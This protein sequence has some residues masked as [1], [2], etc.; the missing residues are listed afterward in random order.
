LKGTLCALLAGTAFCGLA[1]APAAA[2]VTPPAY[3]NFDSNGV[4]LVRGDFLLSFVEGSIGSGEAELALVRTAGS[5]AGGPS[6][7]DGID[8]RLTRSH[9]GGAATVTVTMA[10]KS[11]RFTESGGAFSSSLA[12]GATLAGGGGGFTYTRRDGTRI[13]F[14]D[15]SGNPGSGTTNFCK[16]NLQTSC[17]LAPTD[18]STPDGRT[19]TLDWNLNPRCASDYNPDGSLDC[20]YDRRLGA[21][22]ND[23]G[24]SIAFTYAVADASGAQPP[25]GWYQR[26]GA[27][28]DGGAALVGYAYPPSGETEV[29]DTGG[30]KWL[31]A[32]GR[33]RRPGANVD[34][35]TVT[36]NGL[37]N[38]TVA[39][40]GTTTLYSRSADLVTKVATMTVTQVDPDNPDPDPVTTIVS[41]L[42]IDRP[43]L[44]TD[45]LGHSTAFQYDGAGRLTR[46]TAHEGNYVHYDHD[47]RG[48]VTTTTRVP[49]SG[50]GPTIVSSAEFPSDCSS[51]VAC[52][53]PVTTTDERGQ[54]TRYDWDPVY[55]VLDKVTLPAPTPGAAPPQ[56]RFG[57]TLDQASGRYQLTGTSQCQTGEAPACLGTPDEVKSSIVYN[58]DGTIQST[59]TGD[60]TGAPTKTATTKLYYDAIAN[61]VRVDGPLDTDVDT[62][63]FLYN[64]ARELIRTVSPDPDGTNG[65]LRRRAVRNHYVNGRL[66]KV[67]QGNVESPSDPWTQ[68]GTGPGTVPAPAIEMSY[69][70]FARPVQSRLVSGSTV[71]SLTQTSYDALGRVDCM[72]QRMD[73]NDFG[74]SLPGACTLTTPNGAEGPDR[75]V[76]TLYDKAGR[77]AQVRTALGVTGVEA[78]E[79]VGYRPNGQVEFLVDGRGNRT[80]F[81]YDG[82][83]R[84]ERTLYPSTTLAQNFNDSTPADA[85]NTAGAAN[86]GDD[87]LIGYESV[88]GGRTSELAASF[89]NR[90]DETILFGYDLLGRMISKN[91]PGTEPD[92]GYGYDLLGRMTSASRAGDSLT[93]GWDAFGR[94]VKQS[95][96][97]GHYE[98]EYDLAGRRIRLDHPDTFFVIQEYNVTG[99][100]IAIRESGTTLLATYEYD[101]LGRRDRLVLGNGAVTDYEYDAASRLWKLTHDPAGAAYDNTIE[102]TY[103]PAG[104]IAVRTATNNAYA[105]T[106][107][108]N[109][110]TSSSFDGL[111][112]P[113]GVSHDARSNRQTDGSRTYVY[114]S[115]NKS[116]GTSTAPWH[117]DPLDRLSGVSTSPGT[118]PAIAYES[119]VDNLTAERTPG[120]SNVGRRHVFGPGVNEPLVWLEGPAGTTD[121]RF[122][123]ADERGSIVAV[124]D[125]SGAVQNVNRYDEYGRTQNSNP[126][127]QSRFAYTGQRYFGGFGLYHYKNRMYDPKAGRFMQPDPI[128]YD[129]GMNLYAYVGGDPVNFTDPTGLK[130]CGKG[131]HWVDNPTGSRI[132]QCVW[133]GNGGTSNGLNSNRAALVTGGGG[134]FVNAGGGAVCVRNCG[135]PA[136]EGP[137]G[138]IIITAPKYEWVSSGVPFIVQDG[139][140]IPNPIYEKSPYSDTF[141]RAVGIMFAGPMAVIAGVEIATAAASYAVVA[142]YTLTRTVASNLASRP[143]L[144]SQ[145]LIQQIRA[146][147]KGIRDPGG[148]P[149]ALRY[150]VAGSFRGKRGVYEL[151]VHPQ[152]RVIYHFLFRKT[153]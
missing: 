29:T 109:G 60:G 114:D 20:E 74:A 36:S 102:L 105:W 66:E 43:T 37:D 5:A 80:Q 67:E 68:F 122:L 35:T 1:A 59:S 139:R 131:S 148:I 70:D 104:Q 100:L 3:R 116:R 113:L 130:E 138:T 103:N 12:M 145:L 106:G 7:W 94:N 23:F 107:H 118:P 33:I 48:N 112:R 87:E 135:T 121:R 134:S 45:P 146:A 81:V 91:M 86:A 117:Y 120:S 71:H 17:S 147:A 88:A 13:G 123:Q 153:R 57:Y 15:P 152:T 77:V 83:D 2:Q 110:S 151:V 54:I 97:S 78:A 14:A 8:L 56:I 51:T 108:G 62:V 144:N 9:A 89:T 111:N 85:L 22:A 58:A 4:D 31:V 79:T 93:F 44:I 26:T 40:D 52:N 19:V 16:N 11:E 30:R 150:D 126:Y 18:I 124:S 82:H 149:G 137:D 34:S 99:E 95:G 115:E 42:A 25:A 72:A 55:G 46:V 10:T 143:Y 63:H 47:G 73:L 141:D 69:D 41:D 132:P 90:A 53:Q 61:V 76:K 6:Q 142:E 28:F 119:Y 127:W 65:P 136:Q 21:V 133:D 101:Q 38:L 32:P 128:G 24:R 98:S 129:D 75:I 27:S 125:G 96:A 140:Y 39:R 64:G 92:I 49:K 84:L 50:S